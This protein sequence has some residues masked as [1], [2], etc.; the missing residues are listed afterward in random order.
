M[1]PFHLVTVASNPLLVRILWDRI[2]ASG[3]FRMSHIAHPSYDCGTWPQNLR[4]NDVHFFRED[5]RLPIPPADLD[6]LAS[7]EQGPVPTIRNMIMSDRLAAKLPYP[8]VIAYASFLAKRLVTLYQAT[9]PDLI[10][11]NFDG[12]HSSLG[13]AVANR[14]RIPWFVL[15][16][17]P[18]QGGEA[19]FCAELSPASCVNFDG[20]RA[21][22]LYPKAEALLSEFEDRKLTAVAYI[23]PKLFS[24]AFIARQIPAQFASIVRVLRRQRLRRFLR[25]TDFPQSY[26]I[27]SL[28][29]EALRARKNLWS[30]NRRSLLDRPPRRRFVFFGLH[31]QPESSID[32]FAHFFSNQERV[33]ELLSRSVPPTHSILVKLHKSDTPNYSA[34]RLARLARFPGVELVSP[35][36]DAIEFIKGA[37]LVFAIQGTI[38]LEGALLGKPV[39]MFGD[40]PVKVFP[41]VSTVG[42]TIELPQLVR[43]KLAEHP[44]DRS[45]IIAGF[46]EYLAPFYPASGNDWNCRPTDAQIADYVRLIQLLRSRCESESEN[47]RP[48]KELD[49]TENGQL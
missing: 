27:G 22:E 10:I 40:S 37:E 4:D 33:I 29:G 9:G 20:R 35:H 48:S 15:L 36:A 6:F 41:S 23:P 30:L 34:D 11:G 26:S 7:L 14:L 12:L 24:A 19:A 45:Q 42:K 39:I 5:I 2:A 3:E 47:A 49:S 38:G 32:V 1:K 18:L 43:S 44:P 13:F 17:S 28:V 25:F 46:A 31:M 8:E 16:F 21:L